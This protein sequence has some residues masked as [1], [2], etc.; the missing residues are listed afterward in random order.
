MKARGIF[1]MRKEAEKAE[2]RIKR[3]TGAQTVHKPCHFDSKGKLRL[4]K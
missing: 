2:D 1:K 4:G 3:I